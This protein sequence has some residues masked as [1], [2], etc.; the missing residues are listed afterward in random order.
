VSALTRQP[1][2]V[3][4]GSVTALIGTGYAVLAVWQ[5]AHFLTHAHDLGILDQVLWELS[6]LHRPATT[7]RHT[8]LPNLFGDHFDPILLL[9]VPGYWL[10]DSPLCPLIAQAL[11]FAATVPLGF[12]VARQLAVPRWPATILS[13]ALGIHP[14]F[15]S[16]VRF[17]VHQVA[18]A[19]ALLLT[20]VLLAEQRRWRWYGLALAGFI[21]TKESMALY[22]ALFG[23]MLMLRRRWKPGLITLVVGIGYFFL[24]TQLV[25]PALAGERYAYWRLYQELGNSPR[26]LVEHVIRHPIDSL[27]LL[28]STPGKRHTINLMF[29]SFAYLPIL[30]WTVWPMLFMTLGERFWGSSTN[31]WLFRFHYQVVMTSVM[32][33]AT[34]YVLH[35]LRRRFCRSRAALLAASVL[36]LIATAAALPASGVWQ[37]AFTS[38]PSSA[39][40]RWRAALRHIPPAAPVSAQDVFV[41]H[42]S[43]RSVIY[44]FPRVR[45]AEYIVLD[46]ATPS[47]PATQEEIR[48]AQQRLPELGWRVV[49]RRDTTMVFQRTPESRIPPPIG[50]E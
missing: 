37:D 8:P 30:S 12:L 38:P 1:H 9:F 13:V 25:M 2:L 27:A 4:L 7:V 5:H 16:A 47:W 21:L 3:L 31:L 34:L 42:L 22:A 36:V 17:D 23:L 20:T 11:L 14:G 50:W 19:P 41:P 44:Q 29:G 15:T 39:I 32:F 26:Q 18:F 45:D 10:V 46:P 33:V 28:F 24:V 35:D 43:H 40:G 49:W 6:R 48:L